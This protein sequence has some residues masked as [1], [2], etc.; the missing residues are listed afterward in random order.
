MPEWYYLCAATVLTPA[1]PI[2]VMHKVAV[3]NRPAVQALYFDSEPLV[4]I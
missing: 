3:I 4:S 1:D 2:K